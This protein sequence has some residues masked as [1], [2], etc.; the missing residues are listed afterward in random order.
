MT[1]EALQRLGGPAFYRRVAALLLLFVLLIS[2]RHL[3]LLAVSFVVFSHAI[4]WLGERLSPF[5]GSQQR[6]VLA[7]LLL[8]LA[9]ACAA[10]FLSV[11][12]GSGFYSRLSE[13]RPLTERLHELQADLLHRVPAWVP[14][15]DIKEKAPNLLSPAIVYARATGQILLQLLIG[16][17]LAVVYLLNPAEVDAFVSTP[18]AESLLGALRRYLGYLAEAI[19]I[20][21]QLQL[22]VALVNTVFTVPVLLLLRLPHLIAFTGV[23]F[24]SSLVPVVGNLISGAVLIAASYAYRG[25]LGAVFFVVITFILHKIEAY[26]L[27]P[28]LTARHVR[29][30]A[31]VLIVSLIAFEHAFGLIGL[32]LSFPALYV[33]IQVLQDFRSVALPAS[34]AETAESA[35]S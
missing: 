1:Q 16:F 8:L 18:P 4:G 23:I 21:I 22:L 12:A 25:L 30:P 34:D 27:N 26:Y 33:G 31:L 35:A 17:I 28:R 24:L 6:G 15:D 3:A 10:V 5:L 2:F 19:L 20:T 14:I 32:F 9:A 13:G 29:L 11:H 7:V